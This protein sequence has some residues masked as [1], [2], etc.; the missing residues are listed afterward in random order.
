MNTATG[1]STWL[2]ARGREL[3]SAKKGLPEDKLFVVSDGLLPIVNGHKKKKSGV[4]VVF[5]N[6][7]DDYIIKPFT[8]SEDIL[9]NMNLYS[10]LDEPGPWDE[11][12]ALEMDGPLKLLSRLPFLNGRELPEETGDA[13]QPISPNPY[14]P[15]YNIG[16]TKA[17]IIALLDY[18]SKNSRSIAEF[19]VNGNF[20]ARLRRFGENECKKKL[21]DIKEVVSQMDCELMRRKVR[22]FLCP[23][24]KKDDKVAE[25]Y[26]NIWNEICNI[27]KNSPN[28]PILDRKEVVKF[29]GNGASFYSCFLLIKVSVL[30]KKIKEGKVEKEGRKAREAKSKIWAA[31]ERKGYTIYP[32]LPSLNVLANLDKCEPKRWRCYIKKEV[33]EQGL[34]ESIVEPVIQLEPAKGTSSPPQASGTIPTMQSTP[35][36]QE[37]QEQGQ[38]NDRSN[39]VIA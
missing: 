14:Q 19:T 16:W 30:E 6:Y 33:L 1:A 3:K 2:E 5:A 22:R 35:N 32:L 7:P 34:E 29:M 31:I 13:S 39:C 25:V 17:D 10:L 11:A 9:D 20:P 36:P 38:K 18:Y 23:K 21:G 24:S 37:T 12:D 8:F 4:R 15:T 27:A 28:F 26:N